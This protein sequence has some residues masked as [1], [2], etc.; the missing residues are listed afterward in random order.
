MIK[1]V[2]IKN[3]KSFKDIDTT[4]DIFSILVGPNNSGK[5]NFRRALLFLRGVAI[6]NTISESL[7]HACGTLLNIAYDDKSAIEFSLDIMIGSD[8]FYYTL[9]INKGDTDEAYY[10]ENEKLY[11]TASEENKKT[12]VMDNKKGKSKCK[13]MESKDFTAAEFDFQKTAISQLNDVKR[14]ANFIALKRFLSYMWFFDFD[15]EA[16]K[17]DVRYEPGKMLYDPLGYNITGTLFNIK[18]NHPEIFKQIKERL[19]AIISEIEDIDVKRRSE[20]NSLV[21][22][23]YEKNRK[24]PFLL[25]NVS[26]GVLRTLGVITAFLTPPPHPTVMFL[27]EVDKGIHFR[28]VRDIVAFLQSRIAIDEKNK[29]QIILTT[30]NPYLLD[31]IKPEQLIILERTDGATAMKRLPEMKDKVK[32]VKE[33]LEEGTPLGEMWYRGTLGGVPTNE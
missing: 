9:I 30:H 13:E 33:F 17:A 8:V 28:R 11:I 15:P 22:L 7:L 21:L 20:D 23:F 5:T 31:F 26:D 25:T 12:L 24:M 27:E 2:G 29:R 1:R 10:V 4:L 19:C 18:D 3:F 6:G 16:M 14:H 32:V